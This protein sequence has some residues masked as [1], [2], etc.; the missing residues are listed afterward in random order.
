MSRESGGRREGDLLTDDDYQIIDRVEH[1]LADGRALR[2]WWRRHG[3][4]G[5]FR[6][7]FELTRA[8]NQPELSFGFFDEVRLDSGTLPLIGNVQE[9][10]FDQPRV[11][12]AE[13]RRAAAEWMREQV[14]E[15]ALH[16][17]M[18]VSDFRPP[19]A[20]VEPD[21]APPPRFLRS[22]SWCPTEADTRTGFGFEQHYYKL[23]DSGRV[24]RFPQSRRHS[25]ID[26]RELG[27]EYEWV[28][29]KVSIF[30]FNFNV[31]VLGPDRPSI[32]VPLREESYLVVTRDFITDEDDPEPG[33]IGEYGFGYAFIRNQHT[34][35][36]AYGP[37][38]FDAAIELINFRVLPSGETRVRMV[39][40]ANRPEGV[41]NVRLDPVEW[42]FRTADLLTFGMTSRFFAPVRDA[43]S[44]GTAGA[45]TVDPVFA[46]IDIANS[47]SGGA[48]A[49][50]LCISREQLDKRLLLQ[51]F[52]QHYQ[53]VTSSLLTWRQVPDW[54]DR[55]A[56]PRWIVEGRDA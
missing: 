29:L 34:G 31:D 26:L 38:E 56:L 14:R 22:L 35:D 3:V 47:L 20:Y 30:N 24:G 10:L 4:R 18:R 1:Y 41:L 12:R 36:L 8:F 39:F 54:L 9:M 13:G 15:F 48:A 2:R 6:S 53:A 5:R 52:N 28:V 16:Y 51:H 11:P 27:E 32:V 46:Y 21:R 44:A 7:R 40:V 17:F 19:A 42:S 45:P 33:L 55:E 50:E 49:D 37:G 23:R 43:L 25:I